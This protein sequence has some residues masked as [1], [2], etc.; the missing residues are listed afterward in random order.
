MAQKTAFAPRGKMEV[1]SV[2]KRDLWEINLKKQGAP[3]KTPPPGQKFATPPG[4]KA[5]SFGAGALIGLLLIG[6][7][8][9]FRRR[10]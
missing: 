4:T 5:M 10:K 6:L 8:A 3:S 7:F 1:A 9:W 2:V